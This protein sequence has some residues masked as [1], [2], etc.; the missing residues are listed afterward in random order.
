MANKKWFEPRECW[1]HFTYRNG[2]NPFIAWTFSNV[3][4][5]LENYDYI[6]TGAK[7]FHLLDMRNANRPK[8]YIEHKE[9]LREIAITWQADFEKFN[10]S[11]SELANWQ[12]FFEKYGKQYGLL[13][14]F[15]EN[16]IL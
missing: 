14:E 12:G 4:Y 3:L 16:G 5:M 9:A 11:Y 13:K 2:S 7:D 15:R 10:Y 8:H 1:V 6:Q